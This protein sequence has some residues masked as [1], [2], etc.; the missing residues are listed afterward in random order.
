MYICTK[1]MERGREGFWALLSEILSED[2]G[3]PGLGGSGLWPATGL[4]EG[5]F[6]NT[7]APVGGRGKSDSD[8]E[9]YSG[10]CDFS[11]SKNGL[12]HSSTFAA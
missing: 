4:R 11:S 2:D 5:L 7:L 1:F 3:G 8:L 9:K 12:A 6:W 10:D